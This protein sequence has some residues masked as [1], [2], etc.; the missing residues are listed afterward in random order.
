MVLGSFEYTPNL[1]GRKRALRFQSSCD[2]L[3]LRWFDWMALR[4]YAV[5]GWDAHAGM[6]QTHICACLQWGAHDLEFESQEPHLHTLD[7]TE[8]FPP[9]S[10]NVSASLDLSFDQLRAWLLSDKS[11]S[12]LFSSYLTAW[13]QLYFV[14][15]CICKTFHE[16]CIFISGVSKSLNLTV[17]ILPESW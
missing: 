17:I 5:I 10:T 16:T 13:K 12:C 2:W 3:L 15:F 11:Y 7:C 9:L 14:L 8:G 6:T 4:C 1:R